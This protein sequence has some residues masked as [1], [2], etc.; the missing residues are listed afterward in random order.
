MRY[1]ILNMVLIFI[2]SCMPKYSPSTNIDEKKAEQFACKLVNI[3]KSEN[4]NWTWH[5]NDRFTTDFK[6][7]AIFLNKEYMWI[8]IDFPSSLPPIHINNDCQ[9]DLFHH[10]DNKFRTIREERMRTLHKQY[11]DRALK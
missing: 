3:T 4:L 7:A 5:D 8:D 10:L 1:L 2:V 11:F 6:G 9:K